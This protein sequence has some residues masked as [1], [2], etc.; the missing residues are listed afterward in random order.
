MRRVALLGFLVLAVLGAELP[1]VHVHQA[2]T[3]GFYNEECPLA[4]LAVPGWGLPALVPDTL[5]QPDP[6]SGPAP[7]PALVQ[8]AGQARFAFAPRAPPATS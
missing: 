3:P 2:E 1:E 4:R 8:P 7:P 5:L 6:V